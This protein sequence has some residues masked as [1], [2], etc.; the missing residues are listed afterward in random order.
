MTFFLEYLEIIQIEIINKQ[1]FFSFFKN[2]AFLAMLSQGL[3][4]YLHS[5]IIPKEYGNL[6]RE[7]GLDSKKASIYSLYPTPASWW[8]VLSQIIMYMIAS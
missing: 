8:I 5:V 6:E 7:S 1:V 4:L 3:L 2:F